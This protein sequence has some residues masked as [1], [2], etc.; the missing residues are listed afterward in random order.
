MHGV[1]RGTVDADLVADLY[2]KHAGPLAHAL[3]DAFYVDAESIKDAIRYQSSFN[4]IHWETMFKVDMFILKQRPFDAAQFARRTAQV[5]ATNPE[6]TAYVA[7]AED[8]ILA[9]LDWFR[10][11][12]EVS[13]QQWR[14]V[15][16]I[17]K[18]QSKRLDYHY[19]RQWAVQLTVADLLE[20]ALSEAG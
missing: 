17:L 12:G 13:E 15:L 5:V 11:G 3:S 9:K 19:L 10:R 20:R 16:G 2:L 18:V 4:V 6:R 8:T 1:W 7:T 14:D